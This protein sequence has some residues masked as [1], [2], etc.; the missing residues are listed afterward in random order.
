MIMLKL[1]MSGKNLVLELN[2][3]VLS[4]NQIVGFLNFDIS[5]TSG[6]INLIFYMQVHIY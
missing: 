1:G 6:G 3:K 2:T 4:A 5:E